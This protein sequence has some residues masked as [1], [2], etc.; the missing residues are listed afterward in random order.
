VLRLVLGLVLVPQVDI[1]GRMSGE[2][3]QYIDCILILV[4]ATYSD[5]ACR[6]AYGVRTD[7]VHGVET[8]STRS[9]TPKK[10]GIP[11]QTDTAQAP[12]DLLFR[13]RPAPAKCFAEHPYTEGVGT[14]MKKP[15]SAQSSRPILHL[16]QSPQ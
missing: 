7:I 2:V 4:V 9:L 8:Y 6:I 3:F 13:L 10:G 16:R 14:D 1:A 12:N 5:T 15:Q 11:L